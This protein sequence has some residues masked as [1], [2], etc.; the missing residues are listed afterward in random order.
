MRKQRNPFRGTNDCSLFVADAI[1]AITGADV[2]TDYRG[3]YDSKESAFLLIRQLTGG[4]TVE[5]VAEHEFPKHDFKEVPVLFA[6]RGDAVLLDGDEGLAL[7]IVHL[8][9]KHAL[10]VSTNGL[11]KIELSK[12]KRA[13]RVG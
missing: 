3:K 10:F 2:A 6:Q 13:W 1:V 7:G 12:C 4:S 5:D 8:D 11:N 9:G